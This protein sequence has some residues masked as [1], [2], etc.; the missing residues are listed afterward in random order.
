MRRT[1]Q[2][3][4]APRSLPH[5]PR[6]SY[7]VAG[8]KLSKSATTIPTTPI[9]DKQP[10]PHRSSYPRVSPPGILY[11]DAIVPHGATQYSNPLQDPNAITHNEL[12]YHPSIMGR[13][14]YELAYLP[15]GYKIL[16]VGT[17]AILALGVMWTVMTC[18]ISM[19]RG[20]KAGSAERKGKKDVG[21]NGEERR[22]I[23]KVSKYAYRHGSQSGIP[24]DEG[25]D[26]AMNSDSAV[27]SAAQIPFSY[28]GDN[29]NVVESI[30]MKYRPQHTTSHNR[31]RS[32]P[33]RSEGHDRTYTTHRRFSSSPS[34]GPRFGLTLAPTLSVPPS[35]TP[36]T[37][38][39]KSPI[40]FFLDLHPKG[41]LSPDAS[42][43]LVK[44]SSLE[45]QAGRAAFFAPTTT[46]SNPA[47]G[48][49]SPTL[50]YTAGNSNETF[51]LDLSDM[52]ALEAG[53]AP[54][55]GRLHSGSSS[56]SN[57]GSRLIRKSKSFVDE[58]VGMMEGVVDRVAAKIARW[59]DDDGGD[60][61]LLL[62]VAQ[63][64]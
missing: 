30:E 24:L 35:P 7:D 34:A 9:A 55:T 39:N 49:A 45:W 31:P 17:V 32:R 1:L 14:D 54:L 58:G 38:S 4:S 64:H 15:P 40:N 62:P 25:L 8:L 29:G 60:E 28:I 12:P 2:A 63:R 11:P 5:S 48:S 56:P 61:A 19:R 47:S 44:R 37:P 57:R 59:T 51:E 41:L 20:S 53:T 26:S 3:D 10:S 27:T 6:S 18:A 13:V 43:T 22:P 16:F 46:T 52:E 36:S 23:D 50:S 21:N 42:A 33:I